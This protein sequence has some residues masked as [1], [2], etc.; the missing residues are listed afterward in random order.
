MGDR[1]SGW[2]RQKGRKSNIVSVKERK[3]EEKESAGE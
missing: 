1:G 2:G 3:R